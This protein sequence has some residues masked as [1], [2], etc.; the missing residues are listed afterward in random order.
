MLWVGP[1]QRA[2]TP[3]RAIYSSGTVANPILP[4]GEQTEVSFD[5]ALER[6]S[7]DYETL[8]GKYRNDGEFW[9][10]IAYGDSLG[11]ELTVAH[12]HASWDKTKNHPWKS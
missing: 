6:W 8:T 2:T 3:N 4:P 5:M 9:V 7:I 10:D 11:F 1:S 12:L